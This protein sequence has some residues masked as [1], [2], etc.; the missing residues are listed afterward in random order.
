MGILHVA[1]LVMYKPHSVWCFPIHTQL[2]AAKS[3]PDEDVTEE[4]LASSTTS[5]RRESISSVDTD[6]DPKVRRRSSTGDVSR[7]KEKMRSLQRE[8]REVEAMRE[9]TNTN[10]NN[11]VDSDLGVMVTEEEQATGDIA[12]QLGVPQ[13]SRSCDGSIV[14]VAYDL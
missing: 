7:F 3:P 4:D 10:A 6:F 12:D 2:F 9:M 5:S 8:P 14:N 13:T 11:S 1:A